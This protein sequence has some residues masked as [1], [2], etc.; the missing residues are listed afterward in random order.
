[1]TPAKDHAL[2]VLK[3]HGRSF[4]FAGQLLSPVY[5]VRAARL[6]AFCRFVDDIADESSDPEL[7]M[8][9]LDQIKNALQRGH[10]SQPC[11]MDMI[12]LM[13]ELNMPSEPIFTNSANRTRSITTNK[14]TMPK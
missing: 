11:V 1:M 12:A 8:H 4:Y 5:R 3:S 10:S 7:A 14:L 9:E 13:Q 2:A 6:Y